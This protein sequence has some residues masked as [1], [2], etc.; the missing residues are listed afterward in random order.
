M[1]NV[2]PF[3]GV[4]FYMNALLF[5]ISLVLVIGC[6]ALINF[7]TR[8]L[9][10]NKPFVERDADGFL[11]P[12]SYQSHIQYYTDGSVE[13]NVWALSQTRNFHDS[14]AGTSKLKEFIQSQK[15]S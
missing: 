4:S 15:K 2:I 9:I 13:V 8:K 12:E 3:I 10:P 6:W 14:I 11:T 5:L 7:G 1:Y